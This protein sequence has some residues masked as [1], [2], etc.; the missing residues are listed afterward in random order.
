MRISDRSTY[1]GMRSTRVQQHI[2][3]PRVTVYRLLPD[4][5]CVAYWKV[6]DGMTANISTFEPRE[7]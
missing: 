7:G 4:T 5:V 2:E 3:A 1:F 6:P